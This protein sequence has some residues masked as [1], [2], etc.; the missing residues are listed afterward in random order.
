MILCNLFRENILAIAC[1]ILPLAIQAQ[2]GSGSRPLNTFFKV[3]LLDM[4]DPSA[5]AFLAAIE[6][7]V[8]KGITVQVEGGVITTFDGHYLRREDIEGYKFRGEIRSYLPQDFSDEEF[9]YGLQF[10]YKHDTQPRT[11][12]FSRANGSFFQRLNFI[13][14]RDVIAGHVVVGGN[15][16]LA[17]PVPLELEAWA[18]LRR[19]KRT[20]DGVPDDAEWQND[21][22]RLLAS[23]DTY[24][25]PSLGFALRAG[26]AW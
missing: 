6:Q 15:L 24:I 1:L 19:L 14:V 11:G 12:D 13:D 16:P 5:P 10:M 8:A 7:K 23:P 25:V 4:I 20:F 9:Y 22:F 18:G 26:V 21:T 2:D 17:G 3:S